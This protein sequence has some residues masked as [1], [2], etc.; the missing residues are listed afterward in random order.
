MLNPEWRKSPGCG[1]EIPQP[2]SW[3][4]GLAIH[5]SGREHTGRLQIKS[6]SFPLIEYQIV[7]TARGKYGLSV[8]YTHTHEA[9]EN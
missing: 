2:D 8:T 4:A 9:Y 3:P 7:E 6:N 1:K 5:Q